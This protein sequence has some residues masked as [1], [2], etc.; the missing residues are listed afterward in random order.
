MILGVTMDGL[1]MKLIFGPAWKNHLRGA[2]FHKVL[3]DARDKLQGSSKGEGKG[4]AGPTCSQGHDRSSQVSLPGGDGDIS[5]D[6]LLHIGEN[7]NQNS[8]Q[9]G[10]VTE[11]GT[12][13]CAYVK[14]IR[15]IRLGSTERMSQFLVEL[16]N[17]H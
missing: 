10:V 12:G 17:V 6:V 11:V 5:P 3:K 15:S 1:E 4:K 8:S 16:E 2:D 14:N 7:F 13:F 9:S